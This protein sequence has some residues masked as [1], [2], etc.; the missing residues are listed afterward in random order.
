MIS[1]MLILAAISLVLSLV[2]GRWQPFEFTYFDGKVIKLIYFTLTPQAYGDFMKPSGIFDEPGTFFTYVFLIWVVTYH[3]KMSDFPVPLSS[4]TFSVTAIIISSII[5]LKRNKLYLLLSVMSVIAL[6][7]YT[8]AY[9]N[10]L[11]KDYV[12]IGRLSYLDNRSGMFEI[13]FQ[14]VT[15]RKLMYGWED[16]SELLGF[17]F[18]PFVIYGIASSIGFILCVT[19][20]I[21]IKSP[22]VL[23]LFLCFILQKAIFFSTST[24][25]MF[26]F[27]LECMYRI[28]NLKSVKKKESVCDY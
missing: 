27:V 24:V 19:L 6:L 23:F 9:N 13:F 21:K 10:P 7:I 5:M 1:V 18:T 15:L 17:F 22:L 14:E 4:I 25:I 16:G 11:L 2:F 28:E 20:I 12:A 26:I 8:G 3:L